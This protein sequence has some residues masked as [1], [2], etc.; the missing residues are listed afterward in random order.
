MKPMIKHIFS[1]LRLTIVLMVICTYFYPILIAGIARLSDGGGSG[2]VVRH[3][4]RIVG[5]HLIGQSFSRPE[6]FHGRPSATGYNAAGSG[7]SN[8]G[9]SNP[10]YLQ[11]V[12][13]RIQEFYEQN[14]E[15]KD[16]PIPVELITASGSGIDPDVS[17]AAAH[18]Q[19]K[20]VA[21]ARS[22]SEQAVA[23]IV[24]QCTCKPLLGMFGPSHI[25]VLELNKQL[26]AN[27]NK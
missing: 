15:V 6:Y 24:S 11:Q 19:I 20:R 13:A 4:N 10:D 1:A 26:D 23:E 9:P 7:G 18:I 8:K 5:Y 16:I 25:N 2:Q 17:P 12:Q 27:N 3:N 14:P 21:R 22:M